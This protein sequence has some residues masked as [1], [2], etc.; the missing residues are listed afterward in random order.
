MIQRRPENVGGPRPE[1]LA[2]YVDGELDD[3]A[4]QQI[5][6]WLAEH[7]EAAAEVEAQRRLVRLWQEG[8]P[9]EPVEDDWVT[10]LARIETSLPPVAPVPAGASTPWRSVTRLL[11]T[12]AAALL[13]AVLLAGGG[14]AALVLAVLLSRPVSQNPTA[15]SETSEPFPVVLAE[16]VE[17][18]S[19]QGSDIAALVV[20]APPAKGPYELLCR[21]EV[22]LLHIEP[23]EDDMIPLVTMNDNSTA[24]M[25][26]AP[27]AWGK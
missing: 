2:A 4:C 11:L 13:L 24:P 19:M 10:T 21:G 27:L 23:D 17:I 6:G 20:G 7:P 1:Q 8:L 18:I 5:E 9:P 15:L 22:T 14:V 16:E 3:S 12:R 25:I 26:V